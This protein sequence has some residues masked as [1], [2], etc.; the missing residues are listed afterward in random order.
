MNPL[1]LEVVV[2]VVVSYL[3]AFASLYSLNLERI[4]M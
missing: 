2:E 3:L 1:V 4:L